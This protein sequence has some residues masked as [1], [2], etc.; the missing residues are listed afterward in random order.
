MAA[1]PSGAV[2]ADHPLA[3]AAGAEVLRA[4][5]NAVDAAIAAALSSGV[6]QP[7][8]SGLGGGGFALVVA[9]GGHAHFLDF[10][11]TAPAASSRDMFRAAG[12]T[13]STLGGL[14]VAI[15][16][17][18]IGLAALHR[19]HGRVSLDVIAA[20]A[21]RQAEQGFSTGRH[22]E[23][24]LI[25][26][27]GMRALFGEGNRRPGLALAL[28]AWVDTDGA[29]FRTG[30][31]AEDLVA[32]VQAAGGVLSADDLARYTPKERKPLRV[33]W[34]GYTV[35]TAPPPSSGGVAL[36]EMLG[37]TSP[38]TSLPCRIEAATHA[39]SD[40]A[41][42]GGDP[43]FV[44]YDVA[45]LTSAARLAAIRADCTGRPFPPEH[46]APPV[47]PG[48]DHG[49]LHISV[50]DGEGLAVALTTTINTSFGSQVIAPKSGIV[51][52]NEMDDFAA[53]PGE[54]NAFGLVQGE[55]NAI[56]PGKRPLSSMTPTVVLDGTGRPV[57]AVGASGG[58][59]IITATYQVIEN[60]L[61]NGMNAADAVS[62]PRWHHQWQPPVVSLEKGDGRA[63]TLAQA[64]YPIRALERPFCA[65][66]VVVA[67]PDEGGGGRFEAASDPR[68]FGEAVVLP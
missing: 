45:A 7:S 41:A 56:A 39:M 65:V 6:V 3:S 4:G 33:A 5:G 18:G 24:A 42:Y 36:A 51:L 67:H 17:E 35:V 1:P 68:K 14:A 48:E 64:G 43:D 34:G 28:H 13:A 37:A 29:A 21:I 58:P 57:L 23:E 15:P 59:F 61:A 2:A 25:A 55:A 44:P 46:Y 9:K 38:D 62:A 27:P 10:R 52:N 53:R 40:R 31:V 66:Q 8:G 30:W 54:P 20:P 12:K 32:A 19:K 16:A 47:A 63:D 22:L 26:S 50:I 49:T 60:V 11:E